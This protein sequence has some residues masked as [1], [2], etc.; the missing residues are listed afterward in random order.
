MKIGLKEERC[1]GCQ[2]CQMACSVSLFK[3]L[4]PKKSALAVEGE[5]PT[6]G[7]Y[8]IRVCDQCGKCAEA[9]PVEAIAEGDDGVFRIDRDLCTGCLACVE[10]CPFKVMRTITGDD[11][12]FKC[13]LCGECIRLCPRSAVYDLDGDIAEKRWY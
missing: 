12:P 13:T 3:E 7:R 11:I 4:N 1:S 5:F 10:A 8:R 2:V 6:P 9:C